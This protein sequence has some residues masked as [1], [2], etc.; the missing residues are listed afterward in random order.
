MSLAALFLVVFAA[1]HFRLS[2]VETIVLLAGYVGLSAL[3][4]W[5][6]RRERAKIVDEELFEWEKDK[7]DAEFESK[8]SLSRRRLTGENQ[9]I[10]ARVIQALQRLG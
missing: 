8:G 6:R 1:V 4:R 10:A 5:Y 2:A 7:E 3:D 9:I